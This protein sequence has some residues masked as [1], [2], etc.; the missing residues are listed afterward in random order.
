MFFAE[1]SVASGLA[2]F[3]P[4]YLGAEPWTGSKTAIS[5][6]MFA[7]GARPRPPVRPAHRSERMSP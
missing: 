4:A 5:S 1:S 3:C 6:P 2:L 7:P